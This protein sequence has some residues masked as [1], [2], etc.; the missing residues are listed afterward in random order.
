VPRAVKRAEGSGGPSTPGWLGNYL[1]Q[2]FEIEPLDPQTVYGLAFAY[3]EVGDIEPAQKRFQEVLE[4][5][6]PKSLR[7]LARNGLRE[8]AARELK[9]KG[10]R[11]DAVFYLL[12]AMRLFRGKSLEEIREI[13]FEIG[14]LGQYGLDING[15]K[16]SHVLRAQPGRI[17]SVLELVCIMYA[18]FKR[19]EQKIVIGYLAGAGRARVAHVNSSRSSS[20]SRRLSRPSTTSII[21]STKYSHLVLPLLCG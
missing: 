5:Q 7:G 12:D 19:I 2:S 18:G 17:F 6:S 21:P 9:A 20:A 14:V 1:H 11:M 10:P 3:M 13:T 16:S 4:V 8:I 15:A